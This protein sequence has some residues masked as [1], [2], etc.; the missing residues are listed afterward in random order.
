MAGRFCRSSLFIQRNRSVRGRS[1]SRRPR[2]SP[3][4]FKPTLR[5]PDHPLVFT[6]A[7]NPPHARLHGWA[8]CGHRL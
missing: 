4:R 7:R 2:W 1:R 6:K 3:E 5:V 8:S